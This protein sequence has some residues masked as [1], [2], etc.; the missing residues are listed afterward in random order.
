[1]VS[2][3]RSGKL[4]ALFEDYVS[5]PDPL[6]IVFSPGPAHPRRVRVLGVGIY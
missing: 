5:A 2:N 1:M 6:Q 4:V 3:L